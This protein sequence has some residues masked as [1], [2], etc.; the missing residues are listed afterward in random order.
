M[1]AGKI[2]IPS[3]PNYIGCTYK[4]SNNLSN[5]INQQQQK[6]NWNNFFYKIESFI[7]REEALKNISL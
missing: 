6:K 7:N 4:I 5:I 3:S 2:R 1:Y